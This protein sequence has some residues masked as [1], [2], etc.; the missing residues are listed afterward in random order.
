LLSFLRKNP[1]VI[2]AVRKKLGAAKFA[3]ASPS[4]LKKTMREVIA[5]ARGKKSN[6]RYAV[7]GLDAEGR[8]ADL[9]ILTGPNKTQVVARA[10]Q[11]YGKAGYSKIIATQ[12]DKSDFIGRQA[13][14]PKKRTRRN[15]D[16]EL[17]ETFT[18]AEHTGHESIT[19]P[20]GAPRN[21]DELGDLVEFK[22]VDNDGHKY[23]V[24]LEQQGVAAKLAAHQYADGR[25]ELFLVSAPGKPLPNFRD[26]LPHGSHI[27]EVTYRA[28]KSHLGDTTPQL[29]YHRLGEETGNPPVFHVNKDGELIF[30][31][32]EY[33][34]TER[35]IHN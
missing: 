30:K 9:G 4:L 22:W 29:Y 2:D 13:F 5:D 34:I 6:P 15:P 26:Y 33:W 12:S 31:G 1:T 10:Q 27:Y 19:A 25:Q 20:T 21:L 18:G 35:G 24:N 11:I 16:G 17:Y 14:F 23:T 32:G 28:Q 7:T 8:E 3:T